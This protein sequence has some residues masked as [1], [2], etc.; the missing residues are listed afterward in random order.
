[1]PGPGV[2]DFRGD[3]GY[4]VD[5]YTDTQNTGTNIKRHLK[6]GTDIT[7]SE[8]N[9]G[10]IIAFPKNKFIFGEE[11]DYLWPI[12]ARERALVGPALTQNPGWDDGL[13]F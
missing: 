6:I 8:G 1:I 11:I 3:G 7:L 4:K 13:N 2:Y 10:H 5:I 12:P 9:K